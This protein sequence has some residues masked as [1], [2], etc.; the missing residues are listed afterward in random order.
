MTLD[1]IAATY[2]RHLPPGELQAFRVDALDHLGVPVVSARLIQDD[3]TTLEGIG[4]GASAEEAMVG[5]LGELSEEAHCEQALRAMLRT[6]GSYVELV[7]AHGACGVVDPL[8]LCLPAGSDY[9]PDKPLSWVRARRVSSGETVFVPEEFA[10]D[11][12]RQLHCA[13]PLVTPITNGLGAGLSF[14]QALVHGLLELLQ[15]DGNVLS[16]RA[17]DRGVAI[18]IDAASLHDAAVAELLARYRAQGIDVTMKVAATDFGM[19]NV[20][21]V[22]CETRPAD[23]LPLRLSACGEAV[24]PDRERALRKALLEF[25]G[26]RCRKSFRHGQ[27]EQI[28][29][30]VPAG[31]LD[32]VVATIDPAAEEPRAL[33]A[34]V[35]WLGADDAFM[36]RLLAPVFT[37][38][39]RVSIGTLPTVPS[40]SADA[41]AARLGIVAT[42]LADAGLE[43]LAMDY[44]P[45]GGSVFACKAIV[46]GLEAETLSYHRIGERGVRRLLDRGSE[47][48]V[49]GAPRHG[50]RRVALTAAAEERLGGPAWLDTAA[51]DAAIGALY[52][53]YREPGGHA[54]Q[55]FMQ[56]RG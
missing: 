39:S 2:R 34:M 3:G 24:H 47:W 50:M 1:D 52:P 11:S 35:E 31:Y 56:S 48:V 41:P 40:G 37:V 14:E 18:D 12:P 30:L 21:V 32:R 10:A 54:A 17:L 49:V 38:R 51:V 44:S 23:G 42:R 25:A 20:V 15:R 6:Q 26:S 16:Y 53:L 46:P 13:A 5:A 33:Q 28:A 7:D 27:F 45:P 22:G 43:V 9:S 29:P 4:Y 19:L 8:T 55:L 36:R